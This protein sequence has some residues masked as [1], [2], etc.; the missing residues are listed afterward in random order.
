MSKKKAVKKKAKKN[1]AK[2]RAAKYEPKLSVNASFIDVINV[3]VGKT[4]KE[5]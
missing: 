2:K 5:K 3:A 1:P 4:A